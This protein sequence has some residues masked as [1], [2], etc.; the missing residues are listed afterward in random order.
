M[1][2]SLINMVK[3]G[4]LSVLLL[5][6]AQL[7]FAHTH[8]TQQTPAPNATVEAP[9]EVA[10]DFTEGLEPAFSTLTV[11]D[12]AGKQ[13]NSAKSAV[14]ANNK[15]HMSVALGDLKTGAYQVKWTAVADDDHLT[16]GHYLFNVK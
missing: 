16:Q 4:G 5:A 15:K 11:V 9:H 7:A 10:V 3:H 6:T 14:D 1:N 12:A 13:V 2:T 8:P